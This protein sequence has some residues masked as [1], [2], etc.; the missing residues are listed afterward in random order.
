MEPELYSLFILNNINKEK[1]ISFLG[2]FSSEL[3]ILD[4][5]K[6]LYQ[7]RIEKTVLEY[8]AQITNNNLTEFE[9]EIL[10]FSINSA[11]RDLQKL[12][13]LSLT[14]DSL[15]EFVKTI[16]GGMADYTIVRHRINEVLKNTNNLSG[17]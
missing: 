12:K 17:K 9:S 1:I 6:E 2:T 7:K 15:R 4:Y 16:S 11:K 3:F 5:L 10:N 14:Q 8:E 13:T